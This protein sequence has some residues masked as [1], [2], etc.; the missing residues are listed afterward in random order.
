MKQNILIAILIIICISCT[1]PA[2]ETPANPLPTIEGESPLRLTA[3]ANNETVAEPQLDAA[4]PNEP[5]TEAQ[6]E[7][8]E[9]IESTVGE[10]LDLI[11][12]IL[13][14]YTNDEHGWME[15]VN[16]DTGAA[17]LAGSWEDQF[18]YDD[19]HAVITLSGGDMWTG[20][21]ISTWFEGESMVEV[22]NTIGYAAAA[23]GNHEFDFALDKLA[24]N[25]ANSTFPFVSANV[26]YADNPGETP[27][28]YGIKPY[29]I[30]SLDSGLRVGIT[31]LTTIKTPTTTNPAY[32]R[33]FVFIGYETALRQII[34][35]IAEEN[36]DMILVPGHVCA[37][38]LRMLAGQ[39]SDLPIDLL[40]GGHCNELVAD[41]FGSSVILIG[42]SHMATYAWADL[43][44]DLDTGEMISRE[45]GTEFTSSR[46]EPNAEVADV[47]GR[48]QD[49]TDKELS[50]VIGYLDQPV[51]RR[52]E[53][54]Q[55]LIT[56]S[57]LLGYPAADIALTNLGGF[58][59]DLPAGEITQGEIVGVF[60]FNNVIIE[61]QLTGQEVLS[62]LA[63][64]SRSLAVGGVER[65]LAGRYRL[66]KSGE[67]LDVNE[68]YSVL[69][70]DFMYA[71]GDDYDMLAEFDP[72]GYNT[73]IDWRQPLIDWIEAQGSSE[74]RPLDE[75]IGDLR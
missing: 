45:Y 55:N 9:S 22:M 58:R 39:V 56:S 20:P 59:A 74:G 7:N 48:W 32:V 21:A 73:A 36:V 5:V 69:V 4:E 29:T 31:G 14:L 42:G 47:V 10:D 15:G 27:L 64:R 49:E 30:V 43:T 75:A 53:N 11:Q 51:F 60:P 8:A 71:G 17:H 13:I 41:D 66:T 38:E 68:T 46:V 6:I 18:D 70:N 62:I 67:E 72:D 25:A 12:R 28:E 26:R 19:Y 2:A 63:S 65:N 52:S 37:E 35:Q 23:V 24:E 34:P 44:L 3:A 16:P 57:W 1:S 61:L 50:V 33:D 40:G 54:Q